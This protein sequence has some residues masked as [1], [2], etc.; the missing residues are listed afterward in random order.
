MFGVSGDL[1]DRTVAW[2][3][4]SPIFGSDP[5]EL[6]QDCDGR[7]IRWS[8]YGQYSDFGW[9]IDHVRPIALGGLD[10][11]G[12]KRARHWRGNTSAGGLLGQVLGRR[13]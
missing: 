6:R 2:L 7:L 3:A 11:I 5:N 13:G 8:E 1:L 4:A 10:S 9:Q 12:N